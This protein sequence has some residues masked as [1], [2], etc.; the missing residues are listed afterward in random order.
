MTLEKLNSICF[1]CWLPQLCEALGWK[2]CLWSSLQLKGHKGENFFL[3]LY[4]LLFST[5]LSSKCWLISVTIIFS[6][7][8][9]GISN[10]LVGIWFS[11]F[12]FNSLL[13]LV[14][15]RPA[16]KNFNPVSCHFRNLNV[17]DFFF[18][19]NLIFFF[20]VHFQ[21]FVSVCFFFRWHIQI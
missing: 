14:F 15:T 6:K 17:E 3:K 2:S 9:P 19:L 20:F 11:I 12:F 13:T 5:S 1:Y 16:F 8:F 18:L 10:K 4:C 7:T 21:G